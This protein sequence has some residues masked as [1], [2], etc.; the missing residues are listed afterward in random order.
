MATT[1]SGQHRVQLV[2]IWVGA[3]VAVVT[4]ALSM[5]ASMSAK[6]MA[7]G[8]RVEIETTST[9]THP[10]QGEPAWK[11]WVAPITDHTT[12]VGL[13]RR[14]AFRKPF[15]HVPAVH[16]ALALVQV[17][18]LE[19][20]LSRIG[21]S[22]PIGGTAEGDIA[23]RLAGI[24]VLC[25]AEKPT[26]HD[27]QLQIGVGLPRHAGRFLVKHLK[28]ASPNAKIFEMMRDAGHFRP[29][30]SLNNLSGDEN[31]SLNFGVFV[32]ALDA[33]WIATAASPE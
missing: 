6:E 19:R 23:D 14:V 20:M 1:D 24:H 18:P 3:I 2:G 33:T 9:S 22:P 15:M 5:F 11:P 17:E 4:A 13:Q 25:F 29:G 27:F 12:Y 8:V 28:T 7:A 26:P 30:A 16:A 31:Y 32:G 21:Y 10:R